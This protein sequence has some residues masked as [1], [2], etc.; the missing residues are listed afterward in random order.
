[1]EVSSHSKP[2][3]SSSS[4]SPSPA[5]VASSQ[6]R[7]RDSG[8]CSTSEI[9]EIPSYCIDNLNS[10]QLGKGTYGIVEKT[11]YR[12]S[13][14]HDF[15]PAAIKYTSPLHLSTLIREAKI[16]WA[17]KDNPNIIEIYGIYRDP[18]HGTG[19][20][21][22][23]MDCGSMADLVYDRKSIDYTIDHAA[24]WLFQLSSAVNTFHIAQQVH[25]DLKL[26]NMLLCNRYRTM[27]LCDFGTFTAMHQ[28]MTSNRGTP[29]TMAPEVFRCENYDTKSDIYSIGIIMW[30]IIAR[31]HPY[32]RNLSVPGLLY[33]VAVANL[34]PPELEV[35]EILSDFYKKCWHE[36][37]DERPTAADCVEYF[38]ILKL[39]YPKGDVPLSDANINGPAA[40]PPPR[41][42]RPS[43]L[44]SAS[45]SGLGTNGRTPT[46]SN[47]LNP[48]AVNAHRRNR[49]E[50]IQTKPG[51]LPYPEGGGETSASGVFRVPRSQSEAKHLRDAARA[52][53]GQRQPHREA[54]APP[55][56]YRRDSNDEE[57]K[58]VFM[59]LSR[60]ERT[61]AVDPDT[62]DQKS[63]D[64]FYEHGLSNKE[65]ADALVLKK[66]VMRAKHEKLSRWPQHERHSE[67]LERKNYLQREIAKYEW[68]S[69]D[70]DSIISE[71][72]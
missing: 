66:E 59:E 1:M 41:A 18:R 4:H 24:T 8:L 51:E 56:G 5:S 7:T 70:D 65:L 44:G 31:N 60:D 63:L 3:S 21:M 68:K 22:E 39:Q 71:R 64:I 72:L 43:P 14:K 52:K 58:A 23:Y 50:T 48:S 15:R 53:S 12:K 57:S 54:P 69:E 17:L 6:R 45:G 55:G 27:K 10:H 62:R 30:Q 28:S 19:V 36:N 13:K 25:R 16:M 29:I 40:T 61:S 33:N 32:N 46:A 9:I 38:G 11:K 26:Q 67:L 2:S 42:Y 37:P 47:H 34:R 20:V 35:N 49:S